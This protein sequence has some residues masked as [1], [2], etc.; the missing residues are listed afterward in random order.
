MCANFHDIFEKK[1][2]GL[3]LAGEEIRVVYPEPDFR[4]Y[5]D[6]W[7]HGNRG[8]GSR[9][10]VWSLV[11]NQLPIRAATRDGQTCNFFLIT[12]LIFVFTR[13]IISGL[14]FSLPPSPGSR[15]RLS[16]LPTYVRTVRALRFSREKTSAF[17]SR[18]DWPPCLLYASDIVVSLRGF[19]YTSFGYP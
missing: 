16:S 13:P 3:S 2:R 9:C 6:M 1:R 15:C 7:V 8:D 19:G 5:L 18:V 10:S 14:P 4:C 12:Q 17:S 11:G